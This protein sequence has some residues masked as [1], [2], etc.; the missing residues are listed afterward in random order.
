MFKALQAGAVQHQEF[1]LLCDKHVR[2]PRA[3]EQA[4]RG[5]EEQSPAQFV[6]NDALA[7]SVPASAKSATPYAMACGN[8][9]IA[10]AAPPVMSPA[11]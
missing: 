8:T 4:V 6:E 10:A 11:R 1:G 2:G 9:T 5:G 7:A 3:G